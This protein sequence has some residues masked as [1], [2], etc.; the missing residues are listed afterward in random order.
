MHKENIAT[1]VKDKDG[2]SDKYTP[3]GGLG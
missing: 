1:H 2:E 3:W